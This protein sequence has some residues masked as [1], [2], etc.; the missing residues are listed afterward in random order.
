MV[1][2]GNLLTTLYSIN[3]P[4]VWQ[5]GYQEHHQHCVEDLK[6]VHNPSDKILYLE[7][8][9]GLVHRKC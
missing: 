6:L 2:G 3:K 9:E 8:V 7:W 1:L 4:A 5:W